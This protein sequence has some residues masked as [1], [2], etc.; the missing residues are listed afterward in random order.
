MSHPPNAHDREVLCWPNASTPYN[1]RRPAGCGYKKWHPYQILGPPEDLPPYGDS[2]R[3]FA[4]SN[5]SG[6]A[7]YVAGG[8][9]YSGSHDCDQRH[10][11]QKTEFPTPL[12]FGSEFQAFG[13]QLVNPY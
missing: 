12:T 4:Y 8:D 13:P 7:G 11:R 6:P 10:Y 1:D 2:T 5:M 3:A 9:E